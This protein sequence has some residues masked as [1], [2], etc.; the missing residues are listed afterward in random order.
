M[1]KLSIIVVFLISYTA[2]CQ[3]FIVAENKNDGRS[4]DLT[5]G[6]VISTNLSAKLVIDSDKST[7]TLTVDKDKASYNIDETIIYGDQRV[8]NC[9]NLSQKIQLIYNDIKPTFITVSEEESDFVFFVDIIKHKN[10]NLRNNGTTKKKPEK[11]RS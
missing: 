10:L 2:N 3:S 9:S 11:T 8:L 6:E 1:K 4:R 5:S 7:V